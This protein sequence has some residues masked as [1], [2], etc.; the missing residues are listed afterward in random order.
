MVADRA[1]ALQLRAT[2]RGLDLPDETASYLL[3][4]SRR[5]MASLYD[6]LDVLDEE[7][8]RA[9]RRLTVPFVRD[10]LKQMGSQ[11]DNIA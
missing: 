4:R 6:V 1:Q 9:Q 8:L 10:V 2:H 7:A 5:D 3:S 11:R